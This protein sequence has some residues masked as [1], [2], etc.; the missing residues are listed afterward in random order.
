MHIG[1]V[2]LFRRSG[3]AQAFFYIC[4][5]CDLFCGPYIIVGKPRTVYPYVAQILALVIPVG[6]ILGARAFGIDA[7]KD[8]HSEK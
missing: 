6:R 8:K 3:K 7:D 2:I 5:T 1:V 4:N